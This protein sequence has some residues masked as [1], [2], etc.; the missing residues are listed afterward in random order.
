V[1]PADRDAH[2]RFLNAYYRRV[3]H[4]YDASRRFFLFGRDR[5]LAELLAE[6]WDSLIE[7]GPG[8][9]RN[10]VKLRAAR[11]TARYGAVEASDEMLAMARRRCRW[12][13]LRQGFAEDADYS[14]LLGASP[15]RIL[16]SYC[17]SMVQDGDAALTSARR[18]LAP[19]G[20]VVVVD[21]GDLEGL[22]LRGAMRRFLRAFHVA[23]PSAALLR[24][25]EAEV[26]WG[27]GRY[28]LIA[29]MK[30][31]TPTAEDQP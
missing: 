15:Q 4:V 9:G 10:L 6:P 21:F 13:T 17:L 5:T 3:K 16:F 20:K 11:P 22:P 18:H 7:V 14:R 28:Y 25:H 23:A 1:T 12:A 27:P 8:T 24:K 19:D 31:L 26:R 2:V 30:P 29:S